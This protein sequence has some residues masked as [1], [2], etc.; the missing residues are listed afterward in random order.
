[1]THFTPTVSIPIPN[2]WAQLSQIKAEENSSPVAGPGRRMTCKTSGRG[3]SSRTAPPG[4][5]PGWCHAMPCTCYTSGLLQAHGLL[6]TAAPEAFPGKTLPREGRAETRRK[7]TVG[8]VHT[9]LESCSLAVH[10]LKIVLGLEWWQVPAISA[11][12][13]RRGPK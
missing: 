13:E 9:A 12:A 10:S 6:I 2:V 1:M 4:L 5:L 3:S 11:Q 8:T 7:Q